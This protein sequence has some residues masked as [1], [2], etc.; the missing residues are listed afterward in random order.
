MIFTW[1]IYHKY[2]KKKYPERRTFLLGAGVRKFKMCPYTWPKQSGLRPQSR[3]INST[4]QQFFFFIWEVQALFEWLYHKHKK[5]NSK[6]MKA[7][8]LIIGS[9][10]K[11]DTFQHLKFKALRWGQ[12]I[13]RSNIRLIEK[14]VESFFFWPVT[15]QCR[16]AKRTKN[17]FDCQLKRSITCNL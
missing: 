10:L 17:N 16:R 7:A 9:E 6:V 15:E 2:E 4:R 13:K 8:N 1:N 14:M 12:R 3:K 5:S 11:L